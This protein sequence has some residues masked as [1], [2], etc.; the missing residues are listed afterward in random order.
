MSKTDKI[1]LQR[2]AFYF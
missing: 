2:S 1:E